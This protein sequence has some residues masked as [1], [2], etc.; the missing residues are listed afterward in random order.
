MNMEGIDP[1]MAHYMKLVME[2]RKKEKDEEK[3][4]SNTV[5]DM[6]LYGSKD[7]DQI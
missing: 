5:I 7:D 1:V 2:G 6:L 3:E 4:V